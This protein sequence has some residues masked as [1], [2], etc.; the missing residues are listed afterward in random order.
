MLVSTL[1]F[2]K[3]IN[4]NQAAVLLVVNFFIT[5]AY[6]QFAVLIPA[7]SLPAELA[8]IAAYASSITSSI[9]I[10]ETF[11]SLWAVSIIKAFWQLNDLQTERRKWKDQQQQEQQLVAVKVQLEEFVEDSTKEGTRD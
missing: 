3:K 5:G 1:L 7:P 9:P 11:F 8:D 6:D 10:N 2:E 4:Q